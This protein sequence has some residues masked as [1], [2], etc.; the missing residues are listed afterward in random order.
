MTE[1]GSRAGR[2]LVGWLGGGAA[3]FAQGL[4]G[5]MR[6]PD[7]R[8]RA[9]QRRTVWTLVAAQALGGLGTT[10]GIAVAAL[11]AARISGSTSLAGLAQ[12]CQVLGAAVASFL[13]AHLMG[14]RG[15]REGLLLGYVLGSVGA[16][17]CVVAGVVGSFAT[18]LVGACL[19]GAT[20]AANGQSRYAATDLAKPAQRARA[21]STVVWATTIGAVAGPN[22]TGVAG[23][24]AEHVGIPR[25]TGPFVVALVGMLLAGAVIAVCLRPDPLLVARDAALAHAPVA[26]SGPH[27]ARVLTVAR[28]RPGVAAGVAALALGHA[29]MVSVMVMTPLHMSE[30]HAGL[31]IIGI[32]ISVHVLGM[33]AFAP[34]VGW[35]ADRFGRPRVLMAA[36]VVL[37]LALL[38][39]GTSPMGA[40]WRI[41]AGLFLLGVGW[42]MSTVAASALLSESAPDAVRTDVQGA[43][44]LVMGLVAAAA[45]ALAGLIVGVLD[46]AALTLFAALLAAGVA[47]AAELARRTTGPRPAEDEPVTW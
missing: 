11:L 18:L 47:T 19:L 45:G 43:A 21:L 26:R 6:W 32:V 1:T 38:L 7:H 3:G 27:W 14:R 37:L 23:R 36:S 15:R 41:G 29:V 25:L 9:V 28:E 4:A 10:I 39:A 30:G 34:V 40:S 46:Y 17:M 13:L 5:G 12:T 35:S 31:Q 16:A 2:R 33:Y 22:L 44:D 8:I 42:S 20:T 24:L